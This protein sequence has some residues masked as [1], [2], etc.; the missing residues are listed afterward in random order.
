MKVIEDKNREELRVFATQ[1][2]QSLF[3]TYTNSPLLF[4]TSGGSSFELLENLKIEHPRFSIG[5]LDERYS[6]DSSSNNFVTLFQ[7]QFF[8]ENEKQFLHVIDTRVQ[9]GE[10]LDEFSSRFD[11]LLKDW[12]EE[13]S[14]G[15]IVATLGMGSDGHIAGIMPYPENAVIFEGLFNDPRRFVVGYDA[16]SKNKY[17]LRATTNIPFLKEID[18]AVGY[19]TGDNKKEAFSRVIGQGTL[20]ATPARVMHEM[21]NVTIFTD[22]EQ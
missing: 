1:E 13:N 4:L 6:T 14:E 3:K 21:K 9:N 12:K 15:V 10:S 19:I 18:F 20:H 8:K 22:I 11:T 16:E 5:V 17:S 7:S 2:L